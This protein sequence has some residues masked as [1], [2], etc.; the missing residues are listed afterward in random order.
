LIDSD[1]VREADAGAAV[2][3]EA[4]E[5]AAVAGLCADERF[6]AQ[7]SV[8]RASGVLIADDL[9][10]TAGH[11]FKGDEDCRRFRYVFGYTLEPGETAP[12][13]ERDDVYECAELVQRIESPLDARCQWDL[14]VIRLSRPVHAGLVPVQLRSG[15][16]GATAVAGEPLAVIGFPSGLPAK[17]DLGARVIDPRAEHGD[18]FTLDSDTFFASSG[19]GVFDGDGRL[20]GIFARGGTDFDH[21]DAGG[22]S[23]SHRVEDAGAGTASSYEEAT[24]SAA[25]LP[26]LG[27]RSTALPGASCALQRDCDAVACEPVAASRT[28]AVARDPVSSSAGCSVS[29]PSAS[30]GP[31]GSVLALLALALLLYALRTYLRHRLP[32]SATSLAIAAIVAVRASARCSAPCQGSVCASSSARRATAIAGSSSPASGSSGSAS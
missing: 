6:S 31:G 3:I 12:H 9:L 30:P 19:S 21:D 29:S 5:L 2:A 18:Y 17:V 20:L 4:P 15:P 24:F 13:V 1:D 28:L 25:L 26:L 16:T 10:V 27:E 23:R 14:A 32:S 8:V 22:C 7:P 11:V